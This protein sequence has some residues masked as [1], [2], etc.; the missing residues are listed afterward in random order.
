[1]KNV[2]VI[3]STLI[4][5]VLGCAIGGCAEDAAP[6]DA[7]ETSSPIT[8]RLPT[9]TCPAGSLCLYQDAN[10]EGWALEVRDTSHCVNLPTFYNDAVSAIQNNTGYSI[11]VYE[12]ADCEAGG[13]KN[14][15]LNAGY[16]VPNLSLGGVKDALNKTVDALKIGSGYHLN[17]VVTS[18][19]IFAPA[20]APPPPATTTPPPPAPTTTTPPSDPPAPSATAS[21]GVPGANCSVAR[22]AE[23]PLTCANTPSPMYGLPVNHGTQVDYLRT[24]LSYFRCWALGDP[25]AGGNSTWY[26]TVGDDNG[27]AGWVPAVIMQT[28]D[29]FD[30][31][32]TSFGLPHC[33]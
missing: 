12:N 20:A 7:A 32:P 17:D 30:A 26:Y 10:Y 29:R 6:E 3:S 27:V 18:V 24:S 1:M 5:L 16:T 25:H 14:L 2:N 11:T 8:R 4:G 28:S 13:G 22:G 15:T 23:Y 31:D 19:R 9:S 21:V 33:P